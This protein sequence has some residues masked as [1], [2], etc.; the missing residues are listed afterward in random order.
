MNN[1]YVLLAF[2][3]CLFS[4][5]H[6]EIPT[7]EKNALNQM[8]QQTNGDQWINN[9]LWSQN[10][11][12]QR[13]GITCNDD[14]THVVSITLPYNELQGNLPESLADLTQL[15]YLDLSSNNLSGG[16]PL[17][18]WR[19]P[20]LSHVNLSSNSLST[21]LLNDTQTVSPIQYL[22][23][24]DNAFSGN[25]PE[26][27]TQLTH[28]STLYLSDNQFSGNIPDISLL[29][30]LVHVYLDHNELSGIIPARI[31]NLNLLQTLRLNNNDLSG[32]IPQ[33]LGNLTKLV[34][35]DLSNNQLT[36]AIPT[37]L[38]NL[39]LLQR[40]N[41]NSNKLSGE[42]PG[43]MY[44]CSRLNAI[45]LKSNMLQGPVP[46]EWLSLTALEDNYCDFRWNAL[47]TNNPSLKI[48][49]DTKQKG[50]WEST[51][52]LAPTSLKVEKAS[53]TSV[54][55]SWE[56]P[57][58]QTSQMTYGLYYA[59]QP[60]G[61]FQ[62][63][64]ISGLNN[65][66]YIM[67]NIESGVPYYF[68]MKTM[69]NAHSNNANS[70]ESTFS[71][72]T[73]FSLLS[74]FPV[75]E[76]QALIALFNATSGDFW[77]IRDGWRDQLVGSEC[78][79]HGI[80]CNDNKNS[81][82]WIRLTE[83]LLDGALPEEIQ[84]LSNLVG[85]DLRGNQ[86]SGSIPNTIGNMQNLVHLDLSANELS[87]SIPETLGQLKALESLILYDNQLS[88][89]IPGSLGG[90]TSLQRLY[91]E[92]NHLNGTIPVG[93]AQL[94]KITQMRIH[95]NQLI[96]S[97]PDEMTQLSSL[98]KS[99]SDFRWNGLYSNN[100][101]VVNLLNHYQR[102][103]A[104]WTQSQNVAPQNFRAGRALKNGL[105]VLWDPIAYNMGPGAYEIFR[106]E[107]SSGPFQ[108]HHTT[109]DK[110][111]S[112]LLLT[113]LAQGASCYLRIRTRSYVHTNN[114]NELVSAFS[115]TISVTYTLYLPW[116]S[117]ISDLSIPQDSSIDIPF[118]FGDD[119]VSADQ[120]DLA[121]TSSNTGLI[122][123]DNIQVSGSGEFRTL[124]IT[125]EKDHVG[126]SEITITVTKGELDT[127]ETFTLTVV[128]KENPPPTPTGLNVKS[129]SKYVQLSWDIIEKPFGVKYN[130]YRSTGQNA[131]S[132]RCIHE[133]PLDSYHILKE[134]CFIDFNVINKQLYF[135]KIKS[136]L[137]Q[138]ESIEFSNVVQTTP[139][140]VTYILGDIDGDG[141]KSLHDLIYCL[142]FLSDNAPD[143]QL[144]FYRN[145]IDRLGL[146]DAIYLFQQLAK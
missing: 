30:N 4:T 95:S 6:A 66:T 112:S 119:I 101:Q 62:S 16:I 73:S 102:Q 96:G 52:T 20:H 144:I 121:V 13:K 124:H 58:F 59:H 135:Y 128:A 92:K 36:G 8:Y 107:S 137:N 105:E 53:E 37:T 49:L 23:L 79:W 108:L 127:Q 47:W 56:S 38:G 110:S 12:C 35:L 126:N 141:Q 76:R 117:D 48:F 78:S 69:N 115:P 44:Q 7:A 116:I 125:A 11:A 99:S 18:V 33:D 132:F 143:D 80:E 94:R 133:K 5:A 55:I 14:Q 19:L 123:L 75:I 142:R 57:F 87:G 103:E 74:D 130:V 50:E 1:L 100:S 65:N 45:F 106:S 72:M 29:E 21:G 114:S 28:L 17:A 83:N 111:E 138:L 136:V 26:S 61:P 24:K 104:D 140:N 146:A 22:N 31:G 64:E 32:N 97:I 85:L 77:N 82:I 71:E 9:D 42:L 109:A 93:L 84:N 129:N 60:T 122:P 81:V 39:R 86:L 134:N 43:S 145:S 113:D 89:E 15:K 46:D 131:D 10:D 88:G 118:S 41:F 34:I 51:Q 27:I 139:Q 91:L 63:F 120:L 90:M 25:I 54:I 67:N 68:K 98:E 3:V 40:L 2:F 70:V